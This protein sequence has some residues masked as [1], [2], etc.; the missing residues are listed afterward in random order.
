[1]GML[2]ITPILLGLLC[3]GALVAIVVGILSA[4]SRKSG[5]DRVPCPGCGQTIG[6]FSETCPHCGR[7]LLPPAE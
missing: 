2:G 3:L 6:R 1:M 5:G 4:A 7:E